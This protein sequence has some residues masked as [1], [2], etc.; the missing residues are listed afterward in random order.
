MD[1]L[2]FLQNALSRNP[3]SVLNESLL[4]FTLTISEEELK[5]GMKEAGKMNPT[6]SLSMKLKTQNNFE[7]TINFNLTNREMEGSGN[8]EKAFTKKANQFSKKPEEMIE[9]QKI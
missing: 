2:E 4:S 1:K 3:G 7:D 6:N 8:L 5:R 9:V